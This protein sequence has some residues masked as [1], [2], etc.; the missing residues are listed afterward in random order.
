MWCNCW[1]NWLD[2]Q[3]KSVNTQLCFSYSYIYAGAVLLP[4]S[5]VHLIS[6]RS[7]I[8][9]LLLCK[10]SVIENTYFTFFS[11]F[12]NVTFYTF[13]NSMS[14]SR[15]Q[16]FSPQS[17]EMTAV[18]MNNIKQ[19]KDDHQDLSSIF[20]KNWLV[21]LKIWLGY[22]ANIITQQD[23]WCWWL[24]STDFW[25]LCIKLYVLFL[26]FFF[27]IQKHDFLRFLSCCAFSWTL[28]KL[29]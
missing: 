5:E 13:W 22:D 4:F 16:K 29:I 7:N 3:L 9:H 20:P 27:K 6:V 8:D 15:L 10:S 12:K 11:D 17:F 14:K 2:Q 25:W 19:P 24:T 21:K 28:H 23:V 18:N 26:F 1:S